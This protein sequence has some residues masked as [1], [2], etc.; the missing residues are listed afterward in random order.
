MC[1]NKHQLKI[2][3]VVKLNLTACTDFIHVSNMKG[4]SRTSI[5]TSTSIIYNEVDMKSIMSDGEK[6]LLRLNKEFEIVLLRYTGT[7]DAHLTEYGNFEEKWDGVLSMFNSS[8]ECMKN[9]TVVALLC[10]PR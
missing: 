1:R 6:K 10:C 8:H 7:V 5:G 2:I 3:I 4:K 9:S